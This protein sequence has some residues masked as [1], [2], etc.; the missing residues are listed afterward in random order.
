[1]VIS[2]KREMW[3]TGISLTL[4]IGLMAGLFHSIGSSAYGAYQT[5]DHKL[6]IESI[7]FAV[8]IFFICYGNLLYQ[9]CLLGYYKRRQQHRPASREAL[10]AIYDAPAAPALT[11]LIPSYKEERSVVWQTMMSAALSEY[12]Q[13]NIVLL[14][15]DPYQPKA[16]EDRAK[17]EDARR[18]PQELQSLFDAPLAHYRGEQEAF[19]ARMNSSAADMGDELSRIASH[20]TGV[21]NWLERAAEEFMDGRAIHLLSHADRFYIES[22]ILAPARKHRQRAAELRTLLGEGELLDRAAMEREYAR[23][24]SLFNIRFASFER[25]KYVN[26]CHEANKA[27]NLNSYIGLIGRYWRE[28]ETA[29]GWELHQCGINEANIEI[30]YADYVNTIDA[31]SVMLH[32]Y[33]LRMIH[34]METPGN[35]RLAVIQSS[36]SSFPGCPKGLERTAGAG[37]DVQF[38]THQGYTWWGATFWVGAN[39][40]LR[41]A[42]LEDIREVRMENGHEV[43]IY[44]QDRTVI[45]DTESTI[46]LVEKGWKLHNYPDRMTFSATPPDFGSLLIQRR[47]WSNGGLIIVPKLMKYFWRAPKNLALAKEMFMRFYYLSGTTTACAAA[48]LFFSYPFTPVLNTVWLP[49][50]TVPIFLL[51]ARDLRNAG[52]GYAEALRVTA[53]NLMLFPVMLGGVCKQFQ[54]MVT[55]KK[56]P[57][58]RTPKITGRTAAPALYSLVEFMLPIAFLGFAVNHVEHHRIPHAIFAL[59]NAGALLYTLVFFVGI[60]EAVEDILAGLRLR[61]PAPVRTAEIIHMPTVQDLSATLT[62]VRKSA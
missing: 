45:E 40:M 27:M 31:D 35:D 51:Y 53:L 24:V 11:V 19:R 46:D 44:I 57:F 22:I 10:E 62:G 20:Y 17:L 6:L 21:A 60:R 30:P 33:V 12:A 18:I 5:G 54:Q 34:L 38:L 50:S 52:Y 58:C 49:L 37:I 15:D 7:V 4:T 16:A 8:A 55:G 41:R 14:I 1:M 56:I 2:N 36:C 43:A 32:D 3:F 23:L 47:R 39:A 61:K 25:K 26:L 28:V 42:A 13:K 59:I 29:Q 48:V 9:T